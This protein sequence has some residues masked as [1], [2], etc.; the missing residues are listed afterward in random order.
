MTIYSTN[1]SHLTSD[2]VSV[3]IEGIGGSVSASG[4]SSIDTKFSEERWI[5]AGKLW[6][7]GG[8]VGDKV[9][10]EVVDKD[11]IVAPAGTV[12]NIFAKD[13]RVSPETVFHF[14]YEAPYVARLY[15]FLYIRIKYDATDADARHVYLNIIGHIPSSNA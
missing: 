8:K 15:N 14:A 4:V 13:I 3:R 6:I 10:L 2:Q 12:L 5:N 11:G 1:V 9:G 7:Y